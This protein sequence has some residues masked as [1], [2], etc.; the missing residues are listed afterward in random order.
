MKI[1]GARPEDVAA[2]P[3]ADVRALLAAV[4]AQ[5]D[6]YVALGFLTPAEADEY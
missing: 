4:D 5:L 2:M 3:I 1:T 6:D